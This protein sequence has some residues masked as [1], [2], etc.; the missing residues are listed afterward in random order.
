MYVKPYQNLKKTINNIVEFRYIN[1]NFD[2]ISQFVKFI[3]FLR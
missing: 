2:Y 3:T 1:N